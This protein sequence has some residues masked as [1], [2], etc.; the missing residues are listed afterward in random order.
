MTTLSRPSLGLAQTILAS[1][2]AIALI[3][4]GALAGGGCNA[5]C[6]GG[7]VQASDGC[8]VSAPDS[9]GGCNTDAA[10]PP[11]DN[12]GTLSPSA[13]SVTYCGQ[14]GTLLPT[15]RDLD[16]ARFTLD[17]PAF[18]TVTASH[19][20]V[21]TGQPATNFTI[22]VGQGATCPLNAVVALASGTCPFVTPTVFLPAGDHLVVFTVNAFGEDGPLCP[23]D[24]VATI[25][26]SF[27]AFGSCGEQD[28]GSCG[29]PN[30]TPGCDDFACCETICAF[31]SSCCDFAWDELCV[32]FAIQECG[33]FVYECNSGPGA[34]ANDCVANATEVFANS[35]LA[36]NST[37][38]S[39]DGPNQPECG[40]G[41][42]DTPIHKD[43]WYY[44]VATEDGTF[45]ASTCNITFFDTKI[46]IYD[47]GS[48]L[49]SQIDPTFLPQ[50][51]IEC[52]E[53][54]GDAA[55]ASELSVQVVAGN[56]YLTRV[57]GYLGAGG[58]GEIAFLFEEPVPFPDPDTC[59]TSQGTDP[60]THS[61]DPVPTAQQ[62]A[63][64]GGGIT[65]ANQ[66]AN[67]FDLSQG[68]T[69]G[70]DYLLYCIDFGYGNTGPDI[71]ATINVYVDTDG[72]APLSPGIDLVLIG[73]RTVG[74]PTSTVT[75][76][77]ATFEEPICI[78]A[79]SVIVVEL[80]IPAQ[81]AG[82]ARIAGNP[83]G[84]TAPLYLRSA[85]CGITNFASTA[86]IGFP[87]ANWT[88]SV[89][90]SVSCDGGPGTPCP[91][92]LTG[93]GIVGGADLGQLLNAWGSCPGCPADLTGDGIVNGAD[94]GALLNAWGA[95]PE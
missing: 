33:I 7:A 67:S 24:Y 61:N 69:A 81:T 34:P 14:V 83:A 62:V 15:S 57:G 76:I 66:W 87:A 31:F 84:Q 9:N 8:E 10:N 43:L 46:A 89:I 39:T 12:L 28:A 32:E 35:Q 30:G 25:Q 68:A 52:N 36:F 88:M 86:S 48:E 55:F 47:L 79:N 93:D 45:T 71:I 58:P 23:V 63:C 19:Q 29:L 13:P 17:S 59:E 70:Q 92:D 90:G 94:L 27:G 73:T 51:F 49:P 50:F 42:N 72:G 37:N 4:S 75:R 78:P 11:L 20:V 95:C 6:P 22:F 5:S 53:D 54:C 65:T 44:W 41:E 1:S 74:L 56:V 60:L 82:S 85:A 26:A 40:S 2:A 18:V 3:G 16:W 64:A 21:A 91:A 80:D 77:F 38:A